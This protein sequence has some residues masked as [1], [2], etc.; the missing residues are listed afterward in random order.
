MSVYSLWRSLYKCLWTI[1][2][3][4]LV[5]NKYFIVIFGFCEKFFVSA[6]VFKQTRIGEVQE[7]FI[8]NLQFMISLN[9]I[10]PNF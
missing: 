1:Y 6:F 7:F 8:K 4:C 3:L 10:N 5:I 2:I 9:V